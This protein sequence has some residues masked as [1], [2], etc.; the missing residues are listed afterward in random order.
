MVSDAKEHS[1]LSIV[2]I[3][4]KL[5]KLIFMIILRS[6]EGSISHN[7]TNIL[8]ATRGSCRTIVSDPHAF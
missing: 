7:T 1:K 2:S 4:K 6:R 8:P 5:K 3:K